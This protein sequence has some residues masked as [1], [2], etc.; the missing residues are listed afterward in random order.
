MLPGNYS[1]RIGMRRLLQKSNAS[2]QD[3]STCV[4]HG[5]AIDVIESI[6][7][8]RSRGR[9]RKWSK[10]NVFVLAGKGGGEDPF[11]VSFVTTS[12]RAPCAARLMIA[13]NW[14]CCFVNL[15]YMARHKPELPSAVVIKKLIIAAYECDAGRLAYEL[16][17][18]EQL[19]LRR[20]RRLQCSTANCL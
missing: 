13:S 4:C 2:V 17:T 14:L 3:H 7:V 10:V 9:I 15:A 18:V 1:A 6:Y 20:Q 19:Q 5:L 11:P 8:H 12:L 16:G